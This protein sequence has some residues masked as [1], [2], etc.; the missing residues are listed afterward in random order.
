MRL[1]RTLVPT[2]ALALP[3][4]TVVAPSASAGE[5]GTWTT[6]SLGRVQ[7]IAEPGIHRSP[8]GAL[9]VAYVREAG[10]LQDLG[11]TRISAL[12]P[13]T[14]SGDVVNDWGVLTDPK[15]IGTAGG[16]VRAVFSGLQG[17][18]IG[19]PFDSGR[20]F[21]ST[22]DGTDTGTNRCTGD[23]AGR[24]ST[25]DSTTGCAD[26]GTLLSGGAGG[27]R[28][29]GCGYDDELVHEKPSGKYRRQECGCA[30]FGSAR[31]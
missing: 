3:A 26:D 2:L 17:G 11:W 10:S 28:Q 22:S 9:H 8:D 20:M 18:P 5:P 23:V 29:A 31:V 14:H 15:L 6:V 21:G 4:L 24:R 12:G 1:R 16:G 25:N 30:A 27:H 7:T 19:N 13:T